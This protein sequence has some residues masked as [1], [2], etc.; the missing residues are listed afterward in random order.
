MAPTNEEPRPQPA[1]TSPD[2]DHN[3][4]VRVLVQTK[5]HLVPG[6]KSTDEL[7]CKRENLRGTLANG[8]CLRDWHFRLVEKHPQHAKWIKAHLPAEVWARLSDPSE[9][10]GT[11][12]RPKSTEDAEE[13]RATSLNVPDSPAS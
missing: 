7:R 10:E 5:T 6:D 1:D 9:R 8:F 11:I 3:K 4:A 12:A 13:T 2:D